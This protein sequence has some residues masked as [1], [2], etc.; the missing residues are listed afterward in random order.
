MW[1]LTVVAGADPRHNPDIQGLQ[2]KMVAG[3]NPQ[4]ALPPEKR[5]DSLGAHARN[6]FNLLFNAYDITDVRKKSAL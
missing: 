2:G 3:A 4:Q 1:V 5:Q 6:P